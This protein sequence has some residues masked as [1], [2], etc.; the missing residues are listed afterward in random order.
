M[1]EQTDFCDRQIE[2]DCLRIIATFGVI[3][4]HTCS[5]HW[6]RVGVDTFSWQVF[7]FYESMVRWTVPVFVMIS[8]A[9]FLGR[10]QS[11]TKIFRK[12]IGRIITAYIFWSAAYSVMSFVLYSSGLKWAIKQF[13]L[14]Y[15]HMWFLFMIVGLYIVTP[16]LQRIVE[17]KELMKYFLG[18]SL[19]FTFILPQSIQLVTYRFGSIGQELDGILSNVNLYL[20]LGYV[21][22]FV[23]GYYLNTTKVE[24][25]NRR[26][27]FWLGG[28]GFLATIILTAVF[29]VKGQ[30]ATELFYEYCTV[31]VMLES[32]MVFAVG[33]QS[34]AALHFSSKAKMLIVKLSKYS[35]GAYLVHAMVIE[36]FSRLCGLDALSFNPVFSVPVMGAVVFFISFAISAVIHHIPIL[37][38][39]IV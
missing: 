19:V 7:N 6:G 1:K 28:I 39:Y 32:I 20:T 10:K 17:S 31:N 33:K 24:G 22:Y 5:L 34:L 4:L 36:L 11:V 37:S 25:K 2:L 23:C 21:S 16:F 3:I 29:S 14:G 38:K 12:N 18:V 27:L 8:G 26:I 35:F 13:F 15:Y 9:L 30:K